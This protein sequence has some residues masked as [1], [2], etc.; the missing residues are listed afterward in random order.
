MAIGATATIVAWKLANPAHRNSFI[1]WQLIGI[2]DLVNAVGLG[3]TA[4]LLKPGQR[5]NGGD[6][7]AAAKPGPNVPGPDVSG[8]TSDL[9]RPGLGLEK[10]PE[11][12]RSE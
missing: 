1:L 4:R 12:H 8:L 11:R 7:G 5:I 9:H 3:T 2:A 6:D 10:C